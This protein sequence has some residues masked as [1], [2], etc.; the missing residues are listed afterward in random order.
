MLTVL[1]ALYLG[2]LSSEKEFCLTHTI[3][4]AFRHPSSLL[5]NGHGEYLAVKV[6]VRGR[7]SSWL[8][9]S[10]AVDENAKAA[11]VITCASL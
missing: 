7:L 8:L 4:D 6:G 9:P 2:N 5:K 10:G 1:R 3:L 11:D